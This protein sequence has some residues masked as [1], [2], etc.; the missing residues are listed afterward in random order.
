MHPSTLGSA[1]TFSL[2]RKFLGDQANVSLELVSPDVGAVM[3]ALKHPTAPL[4]EGEIALGGL[5][6]SAS[7][8][9]V[10]T[11][12]SRGETVTLTGHAGMAFGMGVYLNG[13]DAIKAVAP[14]PE[15]AEGF[16]LDDPDA[17]RFVVVRAAYDAGATAKGAIALA[18]GATGT[19]GVEGAVSR[20]FAVVHR[21]HDTEPAA[22]VF[23]ATFASWALP[24]MVD[25]PDDLA[26]GTWLLSEVDGS[27]AL[28]LGV[29]AGYNFSWLREIPG[30]A[31]QGDIGLR[32]QIGASAAFGF[33]VSGK[34]LVVLGRESS[35]P[36]LR[37]RLHKLTKKG[38]N[39]ALDSRVGIKAQLP[40]FF[41]RGHHPEDLVAAIF[42]L[43]ENQ[44]IQALRETREFVDPSVSLQDKLAG[45]LMQLG[46]K[47][48]DEVTGLSPQEIKA[49]YERGRQRMTALIDRFDTLLKNGGHETTSLLLSLSPVEVDELTPILE[50]I[51][52]AG[53][54]AHIQDL[55]R[56]LVARAGFERTPI[57]RII[58]A[59]A[60]TALAAVNNTETA[61]KVRGIAADILAVLEGKALQ[62]LL[63]IV[64]TRIHIDRVKEAVD[65]ASFDRLDALLKDRLAAFLGKQRLMVEDL[66][67][68]RAAI[69]AVLSRADE[70]YTRALEAVKKEQEFTFTSRYT[71]STSKR[72]LVDLTFDLSRPGIGAKLQRAVAGDF[73]DLL[74]NPVDGVT[75]NV[76]ELTHNIARNVPSELVMPF[77]RLSSAATT[78]SSAQLRIME[79]DGRVLV[80][81]VDAT[82]EVKERVSLF[83]ARHGRDSTLTIAATMAVSKS[84]GV[85][86]WNDRAFD[87]TY[88]M[89]RAVRALRLSQLIEECEPI[90]LRYF[91]HA[92]AAPDARDFREWAADLDKALD[93]QDAHSGTHDIGDTRIALTLTAPPE[94]VKAWT[95]APASASASVY[96]ALSKALQRRLKELVTFYAFADPAR[97]ED[98]ASAAPAILF[99]CLRPT[100]NVER[101]AGAH[102]TFD[103]GDELYWDYRDVKNIRV[104]AG[105]EETLAALAGRMQSVAIMLR[106]IPALSRSAQFY[107]PD[108]RRTLI[109]TALEVLHAG[110][111]LPELLGSLLALEERLIRSAVK[112]GIEMARFRAAAAAAPAEAL[113]HLAAFG[114]DLARTFNE[115]VGRHPFLRGAARPLATLLFVE[116]S[117]AFDPAVARLPLA[118]LLDIA[119]V[120]S[121]V[122]TI[123]QMLSAELPPAAILHE[124]RIAAV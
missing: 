64:R 25:A 105:A 18:A 53:G 117:A 66:E 56:R 62:A 50:D 39:F 31:L 78:L 69:H 73:D 122:L 8:R 123:D 1:K 26:P 59:A 120:K 21:F 35:A 104:V 61:R 72:A 48:L 43:N 9:G 118:A 92:F 23:K 29:Q 119:V 46:G 58:E 82:S 103:H 106:G 41:D 99:S 71:Q 52:H 12:G 94:F 107:L 5:K 67:Q 89:E 111:P 84:A 16:A 24:R 49:V 70:F 47:A 44:I 2:N 20:M 32:V 100:T 85:T 96:L 98:L 83:R 40:A 55:V 102:V 91:P 22:D 95:S 45:I 37:L 81:S 34:Y 86:V 27:F 3:E 13:V 4:P 113:S 51:V 17:T 6:A 112:T 42:G 7:G 60:G 68:I 38:W 54:D 36:A 74:V 28:Q 11:L 88:R 115:T 79:D 63:D 65:Q 124:Q 93:G 109:E 101:S 114:D 80:Y 76:A 57:A 90:V 33:D 116:A 108:Q 77:G 30:G 110:S 97:Y 75:L 121:G 14:S 15:L 87:Y 19:F 10:V